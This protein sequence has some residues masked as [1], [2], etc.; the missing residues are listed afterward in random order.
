MQLK[1]HRL[2]GVEGT[3][4]KME[5][6]GRIWASILALI[7]ELFWLSSGNVTLRKVT[8]KNAVNH[9]LLTSP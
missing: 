9:G 5:D 7:K 2:H 8:V 4:K 3:L 1:K 6:K